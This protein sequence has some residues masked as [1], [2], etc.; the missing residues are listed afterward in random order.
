MTRFFGI[1]KGIYCDNFK[2]RI[3]CETMDPFAQ[4]TDDIFGSGNEN[5]NSQP[6]Q[7][8]R[9][10]MKSKQ[11]ERL[12]LRITLLEIFNYELNVTTVTAAK[13]KYQAETR[14]TSRFLIR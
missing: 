7:I 12:V 9:F 14:L 4:I 3:T 10:N 13:K 1:M 6:K 8:S 5:I 2:Q 11:R